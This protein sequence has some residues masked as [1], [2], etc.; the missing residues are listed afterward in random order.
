MNALMGPAIGLMQRLDLAGKFLLIGIL[1]AMPIVSAALDG[2]GLPPEVYAVIET[3][4]WTAMA[5]GGWLFLALYLSLSSAARTLLA[6]VDSL[7][8][9]DLLARTTVG[10]RDE[11]ARVAIRLNDMAREN[12]RLIDEVRGAAEEV[13]GAAAERPPLRPRCWPVRAS[14]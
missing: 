6:T 4:A 12:A 1:L 14:N 10:G 8:E 2:S 3:A 11:L 13:A 7:A 5:L 9:G